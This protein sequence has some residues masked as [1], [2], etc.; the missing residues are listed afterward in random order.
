MKIFEICKELALN[1]GCCINRYNHALRIIYTDPYECG[2]EIDYNRINDRESISVYSGGREVFHYHDG[3]QAD[4]RWYVVSGKWQ[5]LIDELHAKA[6]SDADSLA[7]YKAE[8]ARNKTLLEE[9]RERCLKLV[10]PKDNGSE[11]LSKYEKD[12]IV[13][14]L[15]KNQSWRI[16]HVFRD[17][18]LMFFY[19]WCNL[20]H[21]L[22]CDKGRLV[23]GDWLDEI[24]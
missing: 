22:S 11:N 10:T 2:L 6:L 21:N 18:K 14:E 9:R 5:V 23:S 1:D 19:R 16:L 17:N 12:G 7:M 13:V 3:D 24:S 4:S 15:Q 20:G 8:A